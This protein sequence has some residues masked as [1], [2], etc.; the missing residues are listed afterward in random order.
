[1]TAAPNNPNVPDIVVQ[2]VHIDGPRKGEIDELDKA[3]ITIGRDPASDVVFPKDLRMVSRKHAE[4]KRE[5]NRFLLITHSANGSFVNGELAD[6]TYL[7]QGDVITFAEGGPK[8]SFLYT[9]RAAGT[10]QA[11]RTSPVQAP[12]APRPAA[13]TPR[14]PAR[15]S[16]SQRPAAQGAGPQS[17]QFTIQYGTNIRSFKQPKVTLGKDPANDFVLSHPRVFDHHAEIFFQQNQYFLRDVSGNQATLINSRALVSDTPL[18]ENDIVSFSEGGPRLRYLGAVR[19][20]EILGGS[21][22]PEPPSEPSRPDPLTPDN[23]SDGS[24]GIKG[25]LDSFRKH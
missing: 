6:E 4:I 11:A 24:Q 14:A 23:N 7:K 19:L 9:V 22:E 13:P 12:P 21:S 20:A 10:A 17:A 16:A 2:I 1:M 18:Q 5:G 25:L 3:R 8:I 15:P